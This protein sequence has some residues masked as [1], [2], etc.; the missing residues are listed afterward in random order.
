MVAML[1]PGLNVRLLHLILIH[2]PSWNGSLSSGWVSITA[3]FTIISSILV[4]GNIAFPNKLLGV[5]RLEVGIG[6]EDR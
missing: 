6:G 1:D 5:L 3:R 4:Q 2:K